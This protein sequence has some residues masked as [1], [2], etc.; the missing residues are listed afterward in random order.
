[1]AGL[2]TGRKPGIIRELPR[3]QTKI[4]SVPAKRRVVEFSRIRF[5]FD[6]TNSAATFECPS[7]A[8]HG[9]EAAPASRGCPLNQVRV[10]AAV[11]I[12]Q[13]Q[14]DPGIAQRLREMGLGENQMLRLVSKSASLICQVC[15]ARLALSEQIAALILVEP[16]TVR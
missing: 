5:D 14:T 6:V 10:G 7:F 9:S 16:I 11:R 2:P 3:H 13:L 1:M 8:R 4:G 12:R 15:N